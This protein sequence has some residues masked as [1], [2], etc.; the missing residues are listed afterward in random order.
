MVKKI[1]VS[2]ALLLSVL[3]SNAQLTGVL[4]LSQA[5]DA[6]VVNYPL[7][8]QKQLIDKNTELALQNLQKS[9]LPQVSVLGQASWQSDVTSVSI[10]VPGFNITPPS[11]D[12]YKLV[13]DLSQL[14]YDGGVNR[15]QRNI[16]EQG[17]IIDQQKVEVELYRLREKVQQVFLAVLL[18]D[19]QLKQVALVQKDID[20]GL[21]KVESQVAQGVA[22]RSAVDLLKAEWLRI[23]QR[24]VE[25]ISTR[26]GLIDVLSVFM[27]QA[28]ASEITLITPSEP[29]WET[30]A[31]DRPEW[32]L[33]DA[34]QKLLNTQVK[35]IDNR[36]LPKASLFAQ[37][38][39]GRP[40]LNLLKNEFSFFYLG[41]VRLNW[42]LS[43]FYTHKKEKQII[44]IN[45]SMIEL[46]KES[47][48]MQTKAQL[49][50]QS[51][52]INKIKQLLSSDQEIIS[53]RERVKT[54]AKAQLD[55]QV[56]TAND[57]LREVNAED[58]ARQNWITHQL[59][60]LQAQLNYKTISGK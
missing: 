27:N 13:T 4:T 28:L 10:P 18:V 30:D 11:K 14:L 48:L 7:T 34:Q 20:N 45:Q 60:L 55:N 52:E 15:S 46:Q 54:A 33:L 31:I 36:N 37:A 44:G 2:F 35:L 42:S 24:K 22:F 38:G 50:Q 21:R 40:G 19:E 5:L 29:K 26:K 12:Q 53:L 25:L 9:F 47:F 17:R 57:Y 3:F 41:G 58:L 8:K 39:Y 32:T 51:A 43:N 6:A 1:A 49:K 23:D 56:I 16:Q 59:Q